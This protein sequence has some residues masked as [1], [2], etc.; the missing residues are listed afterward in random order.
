[1]ESRTTPE[2]PL[3]VEDLQRQAVLDALSVQIAVLDASGRIVEVNES[4]RRFARENG[5]D[6]GLE[7]G[8]GLS[9][10]DACHFDGDDDPEGY[11]EKT[12]AGILAVLAGRQPAFSLEYPCHAPD[13]PRW[14]MVTVTSLGKGLDGAV[15]AHLD[16]SPRV[17]AEQESRNRRE[18]MARAARLNSVTVLAGSLVHELAQPL[19]A[20]SLYSDSLATL[21]RQQ[22]LDSSRMLAAVDDLRTQVARAEA[23]VGG[24]RRFMRR[25]ELR[26][27]PRQLDKPI[28]D[29]LE[30]VMPLARRKSTR[31]EVTLPPIPI[32]VLINPLQIEQVMV[33]LLCNA[34]EAMDRFGSTERIVRVLV[35]SDTREARIT[36]SD[37]G[38]GLSPVWADRIFEVFETENETGMGMGLAISRTI[39]EAHEGRLWAEVGTAGAVLHF[40]LPLHDV[41]DS[42]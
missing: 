9:Y 37:T 18:E 31:L 3:P 12:Q 21:A 35:K 23:I 39:V 20:A 4:W 25:G 24:L 13:Q 38:P 7:Q 8:I 22:P 16:I 6:P 11:G 29:A 30:L 28:R 15:V 32:P 14:F 40:T 42:R 2:S 26:T 33:N 5:A 1:M 19:A 27:E 17:L 41:E 10:L 36:V 34:I